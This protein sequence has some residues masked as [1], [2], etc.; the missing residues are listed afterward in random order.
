V[1]FFWGDIEQQSICLGLSRRFWDSFVFRIRP[2]Y[3]LRQAKKTATY[4]IDNLKPIRD[5][6]TVAPQRVDPR[7]ILKADAR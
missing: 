2:C 6:P 1:P 4:P 3:R 7:G 5:L